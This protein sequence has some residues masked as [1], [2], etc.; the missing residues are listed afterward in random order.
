[1]IKDDKSGA[2]LNNDKESLN[3]YRLE[4]KYRNKVDRMNKD[5][6]DIKECLSKI[7]QKIKSLEG[8]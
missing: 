1:M 4:K 6:E 2:V 8:Q 5:L 3:K 7:C